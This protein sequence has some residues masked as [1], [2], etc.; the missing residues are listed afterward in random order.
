MAESSS[1]SGSPFLFTAEQIQAAEERASHPWNPRSE[2]IG[3]HLSRL[4]GLKSAG[5]SLVRI[6]P[7]KESFVYHLHHREDEWIYVLAGRGIAEINEREFEVRS[8]DFLAYP[9]GK[10]AHHLRNEGEDELV[11][12]M[13]GDNKSFEVADFPRLG[14]RMV[15]LDGQPT[16]YDLA[17]GTD[18]RQEDLD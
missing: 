17:D 9:A 11:Y 7:G 5:I 12:L 13:G 1:S 6:P 16:I 18:F 3:T 14:K 15:K 2:L 10:A 8:G 4:A